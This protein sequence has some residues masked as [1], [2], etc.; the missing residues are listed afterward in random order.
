MKHPCLSHSAIKDFRYF[1]LTFMQKV[2][3]Y[4]LA[5]LALLECMSFLE[6]IVSFEHNSLGELL[7]SAWLFLI[8]NIIFVSRSPSSFDC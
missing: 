2:K 1:F 3:I 4:I 7:K 8:R 5:F 6:A